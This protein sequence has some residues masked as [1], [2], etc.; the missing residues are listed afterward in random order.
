MS[1]FSFARLPYIDYLYIDDKI[2]VGQ[3]GAEHKCSK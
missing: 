1:G 2:E 3:R